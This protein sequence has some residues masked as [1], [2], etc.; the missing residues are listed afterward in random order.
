MALNPILAHG[1]NQFGALTPEPTVVIGNSPSMRVLHGVVGNLAGTEVPVMILG[2]SGTGKRSLAVLI[3]KSSPRA[4]ELLLEVECRRLNGDAFEARSRASGQASPFSTA[5]TLLLIEVADLSAAAQSRLAALLTRNE[6]PNNALRPR[7]I[8][9]SR[10]DLDQ[11]IRLGRFR[12]DLYYRFSGVC[13]RIPPLR[14][15]REDLPLLTEFFLDKYSRLF[16][17]PRPQLTPQLLRFL[18]EMNWTRNV[19]ELEDAIRTVVAV[20]DVR[21][22]TTALKASVA[23]SGHPVSGPRESVSLKEAAKAASHQAERELILKV[24]TRTQWNRKRAAQELKISYKALLYK[25]KQIG[26]THEN[27]PV[28]ERGQE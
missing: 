28:Q 4:S 19:T 20:G 22:A 21:I 25:M 5:G 10:K 23:S 9:T 16:S 24:L 8:A 12:E 27:G 18:S 15:R 14:H 17:R 6:S 26:C 7:I 13:L 11:E 3:H 1:L 2:E